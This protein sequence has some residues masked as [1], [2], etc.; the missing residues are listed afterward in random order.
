[1]K[2]VIGRAVEAGEE[3]EIERFIVYRRVCKIE[4]QGTVYPERGRKNSPAARQVSG[5]IW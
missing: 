2:G 1:M 5:V 3:Q 4:R